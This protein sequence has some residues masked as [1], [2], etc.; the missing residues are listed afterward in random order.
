MEYNNDSV[1]DTNVDMPEVAE[2]ASEHSQQHAEDNHG[3][4]TEDDFG[5]K[6]EEFSPPAAVSGEIML[7]LSNV[8]EWAYHP[9]FN[10]RSMDSSLAGLLASAA[11]PQMLAPMEVLSNDDG[12]YEVIDGRRRLLALQARH[13]DDS[14]AEVRCVVYA[15][16]EIDAVENICS[17]AL[18]SEPRTAIQNARAVC[19]LQKAA[20]ITQ[21]AIA[22]RFPALKKDQVSRMTIAVRMVD[23]YPA[24]FGL[25]KDP[26]RVSIDLGVKL[27]Q[28]MKT[29]S[30]EEKQEVLEKTQLL[31]EAAENDSEFAPLTNSTLLGAIGVE[32]QSNA[33]GQGRPDPLAPVNSVDIFGDD[34]QPVGAMKMLADDV[35]RIRLPDPTSMTPDQREVAAT[36]FIAQ[37]RSYFELDASE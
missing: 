12:T 30:D 10:S 14:S 16:T 26:D 32:T 11:D 19:N 2:N 8:G 29:A 25:L 22:E 23:A 33:S 24:V 1:T 27:A 28:F 21:K 37:I 34:D 20:G 35:M 3:I 6:R 15:G 9:C 4:L 5:A 7:P 13:G 17:R 18:G 31:E 36:A